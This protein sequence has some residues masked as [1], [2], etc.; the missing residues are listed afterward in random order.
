[1]KSKTVFQSQLDD[2]EAFKPLEGRDAI[3][4][5]TETIGGGFPSGVAESMQSELE[6]A[7]SGL[8]SADLQDAMESLRAGNTDLDAPDTAEAIIMLTGYPSLLIRDGDFETQ[9]NSVWTGRLDPHR[10]VIKRVIR[11]AARVELSGHPDF[12]WC[13]TCWMLDTDL[14]VTNRHVAQVF[15]RMRQGRW[16]FRPG[17]EVRA[18]FAEEIGGR[19][20]L[21]YLVS[22]L[23]HVEIDERVD[24]AIMRLGKARGKTLRLEPISLDTGLSAVEYLGVIG[25]PAN[26]L[27]NNPQ[28]A[29]NRYFKGQFGVKRFAP[30]MVMDANYRPEIFT[31]NCTTLGGNSG[32][33][34]F[35]VE[36]G[37]AIGLHFGGNA[38]A[39]NY[40]VKA[41]AMQESLK[42]AGVPF[43]AMR[44]ARRSSNDGRDNGASETRASAASFT[45]RN[46]YSADFLG[47]G[48]MA[49]PLPILS[50]QQAAN[51]VKVGGKSE[52]TY[53]N[54]SVVMSKQ[55]RLAYL[56]AVNI[57][58]NEA[59]NPPRQRAF[60]LDPRLEKSLQAGEDLYRNN[61]FDRGHLVR[62]LDPC[63]GSE[64]QSKQANVD[65]MYFP[66]IAPQHEKLNQKIWND[67]EDHILST[68]DQKDWKVSVFTGCV[69]TDHDEIHKPSGIRVPMAFW[70]VVVSR[71]RQNSGGRARGSDMLQAQA[72][73][74]SQA[75][76]VKP[77]DF[78]AVFGEGFETFQV[79]IEQLERMTGLDFHK[80][81]A[82]DTFGMPPDLSE[83]HAR[84]STPETA[85][86]PD[87]NPHFRPLKSLDDVVVANLKDWPRP[88]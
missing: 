81:K 67:L 5:A 21:E 73:V 31:H 36:T 64:A 82:A 22:S 83:S 51:A 56:T 40:A 74:L 34:V 50:P 70:K 72:F 71:G 61:P 25:Y 32:S 46:G 69:F 66:N 76:L 55:R 45:D 8:G 4:F 62:R 42:R 20:A 19:E 11:S 44:G 10:D 85:A 88:R 53:R 37:N 15:S 28:D 63:W 9:P 33:V 57:D 38:Q 3:E 60:V 13:G 47:N 16:E 6:T 29:F 1:M 49:V 59:R 18:D 27:R 17:V 23:E 39:Q 52:I 26:D 54:F 58:G 77:K 41:A 79:T 7:A 86:D 43:Y 48:N 30:G 80:L 35:N 84:E 24:M 87:A 2:A 14:L 78:E 68:V 65:S 75:H 12:T